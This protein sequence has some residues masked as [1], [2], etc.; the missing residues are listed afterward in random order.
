[1][2]HEFAKLTPAQLNDIAD[3]SGYMDTGFEA[4]RFDEINSKGNFVYSVV[5]WCT[6]E[7]E[8]VI[9]KVYISLDANG[10]VNLEF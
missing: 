3:A 7:G 4:A 5:S 8:Y 10:F 9:G 6:N 1:M 2:K